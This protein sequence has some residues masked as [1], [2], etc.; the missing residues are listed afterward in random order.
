MTVVR[1]GD[2]RTFCVSNTRIISLCKNMKLDSSLSPY[3]KPNS[4]CI[5]DLTVRPE[6]IK[7]LEKTLLDNS[8]GKEFMSKTSKAQANVSDF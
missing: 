5:K 6:T 4:R 8:L 1:S 7:I 2:V 3:T